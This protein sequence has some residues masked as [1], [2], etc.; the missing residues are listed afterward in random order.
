MRYL[1]ASFAKDVKVQSWSLYSVCMLFILLR[2][3]VLALWPA[4]DG[5][6]ALSP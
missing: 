3:Y 5:Y 6:L 1:D 2:L 4:V